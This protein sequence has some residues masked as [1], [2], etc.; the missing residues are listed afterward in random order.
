M[1]TGAI[2]DTRIPPTVAAEAE[3][4][5]SSLDLLTICQRFVGYLAGDSLNYLIGFLIY[6]WL[7][8]ILTNSQY[9][10]LSIATSVYQTLMMVAA[11]GIDYVGPGIIREHSLQANALIGHFE[12]VRIGVAMAV[13]LPVLLVIVLWY[14]S[15]GQYDTAI[16]VAASFAMVLARAIDLSYVAVAYGR[17][18]ILASSRVLGLG[19]Y[20]VLLLVLASPERKNLWLIPVLNAG[21]VAI[22]RVVLARQLKKDLPANKNLRVSPVSTGHILAVGSRSGAGQLIMLGFQTL[23]ILYLSKYVSAGYVGQYAMIER[24]YIFGTA[25]LT[26]VFNAFVPI[27]ISDPNHRRGIKWCVRFSAIIGGVGFVGLAVVGPYVA[28]FFAGRRLPQTHGIALWFG[29]AFC[30]LAIAT[31]LY[32][33]LA[34]LKRENEYMVAM[35]LG[36]L[37]MVVSD[38]SLVPRYGLL[39]GALGQLSASAAVLCAASIFVFKGRVAGDGECGATNQCQR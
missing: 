22:G 4:A 2:P 31:P 24:L 16:V 39:G 17:P 12:R 5:S 25:A 27:L 9:A 18:A 29:I 13:C 20:L 7:V 6:A 30:F 11:I 21:G 3:I 23:D 33:V 36:A 14:W 37:A 38:I 26:S 1:S 34:I 28:E 32:G 35:S 19:I 10:Q 15:E 8:R